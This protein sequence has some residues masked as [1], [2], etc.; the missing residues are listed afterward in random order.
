MRGSSMLRKI[1]IATFALA[2]F[3]MVGTAAAAPLVLPADTPLVLDFSNIEQL[4]IGQDAIG[5][6]CIDVPGTTNW[7]CSD[8]WGFLRINTINTS[9]VVDP[10]ADIDDTGI[11]SLYNTTAN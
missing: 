1:A 5:E 10:N 11:G 2:S 4:Y 8:N 6:G 7:G 9:V 3:G